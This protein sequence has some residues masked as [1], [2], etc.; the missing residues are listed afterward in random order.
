MKTSG[1]TFKMA[2]FVVQI[3]T[4]TLFYIWH[5][6]LAAQQKNNKGSY[7]R[8][9]RVSVSDSGHGH[10]AR[11][12]SQST[13]RHCAGYC[14][15]FTEKRRSHNG[16]GPRASR[17][18]TRSVQES[19]A[20]WSTHTSPRIFFSVLISAINRENYSQ[21]MLTHWKS[22]RVLPHRHCSLKGIVKGENKTA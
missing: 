4:L 3:K 11:H 13:G 7:E 21:S 1:L 18:T 10:C 9:V 19:I 2:A 22:D 6:C 17:D 14:W 15:P 20:L 16:N 12:C 5:I 8:L